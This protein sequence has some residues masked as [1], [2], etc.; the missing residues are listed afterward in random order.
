MVKSKRF[1]P[2]VDL[3]HNAEREAAK[4]LGTALQRLNDS[5]EQLRQLHAYREEYAQRLQ[6][7]GNQGMSG[8]ERNEYRQFIIKIGAAIESQTALVAQLE[9]VLEEKKQFW[10]SRRGRSQ[11][12][13]SVLDHYLE[14]ERKLLDRREQREQDDRSGR[15]GNDTGNE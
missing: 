7:L 8:Q 3:A 4:A 9:S 13:D 5:Q 15:T 12:L 6:Q 14:S 10:F 11:A 1:Q 2:I